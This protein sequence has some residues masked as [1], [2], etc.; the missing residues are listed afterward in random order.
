M[1]RICAWAWLFCWPV[2]PVFGASVTQ[3]IGVHREGQTFL[4]F[5][6]NVGASSTTMFEVRRSSTPIMAATDGVSVGPPLDADSYHFLWPDTGT[7]ENLNN[8]FLIPSSASESLDVV[9]TRRLTSAEGLYVGTPEM[10]GCVY[11]GVFTSDDPMAVNPGDNTTIGC[12]AETSQAVPGVVL[13]SDWTQPG[14]PGSNRYRKYFAW[15]GY[16]TWGHHAWGYYGNK[17]ALT[18]SASAYPLVSGTFYPLTLQLHGAGQNE[19]VEPG[20]VSD[21]VNTRGFYLSPV[22]MSLQG[23]NAASSYHAHY[24]SSFWAGYPTLASPTTLQRNATALRVVRY[25][26]ALASLPG[27]P[28]QIDQ[29]RLYLNGASMGGMDVHLGYDLA[30]AGVFAAVNVI[31]GIPTFRRWSGCIGVYGPT[32]ELRLDTTNQL[33]WREW[34]NTTVS[35]TQQRTLPPVLYGWGTDDVIPPCIYKEATD[36]AEA[37][38]QAVISQWILNGGHGNVSVH[39]PGDPTQMYFRFKTNE[40]FLAFSNLTSNDDDGN[41]TVSGQHNLTV[42]FQ[43]ALHSIPGGQP[44]VDTTNSF[45]ASIINSRT[46]VGDVTIRNQQAFF[47][48]LGSTVPW[49]SSATGQIGNAVRN[50]DGSITITGLSMPAMMTTRLALGA[51]TPPPPSPPSAMFVGTDTMTRGDWTMAYGAMGHVIPNDSSV[52][53]AGAVVTSTGLVYTWAASTTDVRALM[54]GNSVGRIAST[55][56]NAT[57]FTIAFDAGDTQVHLVSLYLLDWDNGGARHETI[58]ILDPVTSAVLDTRTM[59][60]FP[61]GQY[62]TWSIT[63]AVTIRITNVGGS[64]AVVN[65]MFLGTGGPLPPPPTWAPSSVTPFHNDGTDQLKFCMDATHCWGPLSR[66]P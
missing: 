21:N 17:F 40:A 25:V 32:P 22:D 7:L 60:M 5:T 51:A 36:T 52:L 41:M 53:P 10:S 29:T 58:D 61:S 42:D 24:P 33:V 12:I 65:G 2:T 4:T 44:I 1:R 50:T 34:A 55:W 28:L 37:A 19:Y 43:S 63:G 47:P 35:V 39:A 27:N 66:I 26:R 14:G 23:I 31:S 16:T 54:K 13:I 38:K 57:S 59:Q 56:Y 8:G 30:N 62:W 3:L 11:Y 64:N 46:A 9:A 20:G 18:Q 6:K 15:E 45:A 48:G 49:S